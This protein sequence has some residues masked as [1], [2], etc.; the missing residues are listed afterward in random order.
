[1]NQ[2]LLIIDAQVAMLENTSRPIY[3]LKKT[4][5]QIQQLIAKARAAHIPLIYIQDDDIG[6]P[7]EADWEVHPS[8][9]PEPGDVRIRK[10]AADAFHQSDLQ[11]ELNRLHSTHLIVTG[12]Q[13]QACVDATTR[14]AAMRGYAVTLASDAHSNAGSSVLSAEQ[15]IAWHNRILDGMY[16]PQ[17]GFEESVGIEVKPSNEIVF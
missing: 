11:S 9:A 12:F 16:G 17:H 3:E 1:M 15:I 4:L 8:L 10:L 5:A 2:A 7:G 13:T 14:G 6:T